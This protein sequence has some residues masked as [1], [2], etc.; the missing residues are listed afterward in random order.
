MPEINQEICYHVIGVM[1]GTSLDGVDIAYCEFKLSGDKWLYKIIEAETIPYNQTWLVRLKELHKQPAFIFPKT[2]AFYGKY[3]GQLINTFIAKHKI[4]VDFIASHGHTIFHQ[5]NKGFTAQIGS[6]ASIYAE[7]GITTINDFRVVDVALGGQGAPLVP[8][9]DQLLFN[10]FEGCLNLGGFSNISFNKDNQRIA[11]DISPC[12][13]IM[14]TVANLL[15]FDFDNEGRIAS[16]GKVNEN[17]FEHLNSLTFY[18]QLPPKSLGIEWVNEHFWPT[19]KQFEIQP[20]DLLATINKHIANQIAQVIKSNNLKSVLTTGGGAFNNTLVNEINFQ[21]RS[22]LVIPNK[23]LVNYKEA[24]IF[25]FLGVLRLRE[26]NNSLMSITGAKKNSIGG[27]I[28][29]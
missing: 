24:L 17:L 7:T 29:G 6:G 14:N 28:W 19:I 21:T 3:I 5:P 12:N 20:E 9:G 10:E 22:A 13:I 8:I 15:G 18:K 23:H 27:A 2:D 11:F 26:T 25:G 16:E 1:S 4:Q